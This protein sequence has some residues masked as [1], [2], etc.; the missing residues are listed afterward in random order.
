MTAKQS[1]PP[2]PDGL[3]DR[4]RDLWRA[5]VPAHAKTEGRFTLI[6]EALRALDRADQARAAVDLEGLTFTTETTKAVHIHPLVRVERESRQLFNK[7]WVE[8][9]FTWRG[10]DAARHRYGD[11]YDDD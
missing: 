8:L 6:E 3:S 4:S 10:E 2:P 5:M 7:I 9:G 1:P 11:E